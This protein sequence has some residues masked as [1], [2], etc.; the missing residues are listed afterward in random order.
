MGESKRTKDSPRAA[1]NEPTDYILDLLFDLMKRL[2]KHEKGGA[3]SGMLE[4][5]DY[6]C[7]VSDKGRACT[8][9]MKSKA[10]FLNY[11]FPEIK[12]MIE[13]LLVYIREIP[14]HENFGR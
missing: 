7:R 6:F 1:A 13:K 9:S 10:L 12:Q 4:K 5:Y 8:Y 11:D 2:D 3:G 14:G